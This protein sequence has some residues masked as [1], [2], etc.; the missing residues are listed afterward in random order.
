[1]EQLV[2]VPDGGTAQDDLTPFESVQVVSEDTSSET[3]NLSGYNQD[4]DR[5]LSVT[6]ILLASNSSAERAAAARELG[7]LGGQTALTHLVAALYDP[8]P[9]VCLAAAE[10]LERLGD[11][12]AI[13]LLADRCD[14]DAEPTAVSPAADLVGESVEQSFADS[15]PISLD[16]LNSAY[17]ESFPHFDSDSSTV[18]EVPQAES[19]EEL[20]DDLELGV[21]EEFRAE[22]A[23]IRKAEHELACRRAEAEARQRAKEENAQRLRLEAITAKAEEEAKRRAEREQQL[24]TELDEIRRAQTQQLKRIEEAEAARTLQ[25]E[26]L[27]M[28]EA[29]ARRCADEQQSRI[30]ELETLKEAAEVESA[31]RHQKE[32]ELQAELESLEKS[33]SEV[34]RHLDEVSAAISDEQK[35]I[36]E[37]E[38]SVHHNIDLERQNSE[39]IERLREEES[40]LQTKLAEIEESVAQL[41]I[42]VRDGDAK[43]SEREESLNQINTRIEELAKSEVNQLE[44]LADAESQLSN[45]EQ[46]R[47]QVE[48]KIRESLERE[49]Q[50]VCE[51]E[52]LRKA[53]ANVAKRIAEVEAQI[54]QLQSAVHGEQERLLELKSDRQTAE[55]ESNQ[56]AGAH[57]TLVVA[58]EALEIAKAEQL[59]KITEAE[60]QVSEAEARAILSVEEE[61][62]LMAEAS[63]LREAAAKSIEAAEALRQ[64]TEAELQRQAAE[65]EQHLVELNSLRNVAREAMLELEERERNLLAEIENLRA[66]EVQKQQLLQE[67]ADRKLIQEE[68]TRK[69]AAELF[70]RNEEEQQRLSTLQAI[71]ANAE[72][73]AEERKQIENKVNLELENLRQS[74]LM[75][76]SRIDMLR[77]EIS[78]ME[79][80]LK[81]RAETEAGLKD[82]VERLR[83]ENESRSKAIRENERKVEAE[84]V[85]ATEETRRLDRL[86]TTL[87]DAEQAVTQRSEAEKQLNA[88]I[89]ILLQAEAEQVTKLADAVS[90]VQ[91]QKE[92]EQSRL[93]QLE[94]LRSQAETESQQRADLERQLQAE[95]ESL[96]KTESKQ[97]KRIN[98]AEQETE[99]R[100]G[101]EAKLQASL[102]LLR[103]EKA[104]QQK[105]IAE[106]TSLL[107]Q[108]QNEADQ[109]AAEH[110]RIRDEVVQLQE[111]ELANSRRLAAEQRQEVEEEGARRIAEEKQRIAELESIRKSLEASVQRVSGNTT[112]LE[113][114]LVTLRKLE[115]EQ[116][117]RLSV[118]QMQVEQA[119]QE[120]KRLA[121]Q[122]ADLQREV[123]EQQAAN[124]LAVDDLHQELE[125]ERNRR[126]REEEKLAQLEEMRRQVEVEAA[127]R[128]EKE[129]QLQEQ[130]EWYSRTRVVELERI[131]EL[132]AERS[133]RAREEEEKLAELEDRRRQ[134]EIE[135]A[136]REEKERQLQAQ[137]DAYRNM[138]VVEH[139]RIEVLESELSKNEAKAEQSPVT[140]FEFKVVDQPLTSA[141]QT[142]LEIE[143]YDSI[144][145]SEPDVQCN[146]SVDLAL[147]EDGSFVILDFDQDAPVALPELS[148]LTLDESQPSVQTNRESHMPSEFETNSQAIGSQ[149]I[150]LVRHEKGIELATEPGS[151]P[152]FILDRLGSDDPAER[153]TALMDL[154]QFG[155]D[156]A[157]SLI[158]RAFDDTVAE[159]R[160][161]AARALF[162]LEHDRAASFTRALREASIERRRRI[163]AAI[164]GCGIANDAI[165]GLLDCSRAKTYDAFSILFLMAKAGEIQPLIR[166]IES[167]SD[168]NVRLAVISL[169]TFSNQPET[170]PAFRRLAVRGS[171]PAEVRS[172]LMEA[173][174]QI[175]SQQREAVQSAA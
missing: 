35:V 8:S 139:E 159:V 140:D 14:H 165:N 55:A 129:R 161:A 40:N 12:S 138:Q 29:D 144:D 108:L 58:I 13:E 5:V 166:S 46:N 94:Q 141:T 96:R 78:Q 88:E 125:E 28:F 106:A 114:E 167:H 131:A 100:K 136:E 85:R 157:F 27:R 38:E 84:G 50:L 118:V 15:L 154:I 80:H 17:V 43:A 79:I 30:A 97:L 67:V 147:D 61:K 145:L 62:R 163:G 148:E 150:D 113:T 16:D 158:T 19:L 98:A 23:A 69:T 132:E 4:D 72:R 33:K 116:I 137:L 45:A 39:K 93:T 127:E 128:E 1:M 173:I 41:E 49:E 10:S 121:E 52:L 115:A 155:G 142:D 169:L 81:G 175:S 82:Q 92:A 153:R 76:S 26:A 56:R 44:R 70:L 120:S 130:L 18:E 105:R 53:D 95:I 91:Q 51:L 146:P 20:Q 21:D 36:A 122:E 37:L 83:K 107:H 172:A 160:Y 42:A 6:Q 170:I 3:D 71:H 103:T 89:A 111:M 22:A 135:A 149:G 7:L 171:L 73:E 104:R 87:S 112:E 31:L 64:Q 63:A 86:K 101:Q 34:Q 126:A 57:Q 117:A 66:E 48:I 102:E 162:D 134:S 123:H 77:K 68:R 60:N 54:S 119:Q 74:E 32:N 109:R 9:E 174:H 11:S 75:Q 151:V 164:G 2:S 124:R 90:L 59:A 65:K 25:E 168:V 152:S 24:K 133:R 99:E 110:A 47:H 143:G 156:E